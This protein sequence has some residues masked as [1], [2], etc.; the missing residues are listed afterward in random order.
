MHVH[1]FLRQHCSSCTLARCFSVSSDFTKGLQDHNRSFTLEGQSTQWCVNSDQ[2]IR[3][4]S[5]SCQT[6]AIKT[7][8]LTESCGSG[9]FQQRNRICL[10]EKELWCYLSAAASSQVYSGYYSQLWRPAHTGRE[11]TREHLCKAPSS[12]WVRPPCV[13]YA[14]FRSHPCRG[15]R[16]W[17]QAARTTH[18]LPSLLPLN[19]RLIYHILGFSCH[20]LYLTCNTVFESACVCCMYVIVIH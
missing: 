6:K 2:R 4:D 7:Q 1:V 14:S 12:L 10:S 16:K 5:L 13:N 18:T 9:T 20:N 8:P 19:P 15:R 3:A 11:R 17:P